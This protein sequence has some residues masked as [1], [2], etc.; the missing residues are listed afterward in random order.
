MD[1]T[2]NSNFERFAEL[3]VRAYWETVKSDDFSMPPNEPVEETIEE[4]LSD[5]SHEAEYRPAS[6]LDGPVHLLRMTGQYGAWLHFGFRYGHR[7]WQLI[8]ASARSDSEFP[9]DLLGPVYS[10]Y[11]APFLQHVTEIANQ[12]TST[13]L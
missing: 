5:I 11:F 12:R 2:S 7:N 8:C 4:L 9:H 13:D 1:K 10:Q 3:F 6:D